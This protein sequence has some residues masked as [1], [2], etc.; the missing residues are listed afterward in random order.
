MERIM[1]L[2]IL[3]LLGTYQCLKAQ[4]KKD[5]VDHEMNS[6]YRIKILGLSETGTWAMVGKY[7]DRNRDTTMVV[8]A[9]VPNT[10]RV[11]II[12]KD[13][14]KSFLKDEAVITFGNNK[15]EYTSLRTL[16]KIIYLHVKHISV[17]PN[18]GQYGIIDESDILSVF[19]VNGKKLYSLNDIKNLP[20]TDQSDKSFVYRKNENG[21]E[22]IDISGNRPKI[23][24]S[25][26]N[27]IKRIEISKSAT[28][29]IIVETERSSMSETLA[30]LNIKNGTVSKPLLPTTKK[31]AYLG[32]IEH[33]SSWIIS[34]NTK[35]LN[36]EI[37][38]IWYGNDGNLINKDQGFNV[39]SNYWYYNTETEDLS[40]LPSQEYNSM[41][42]TRNKRFLLVY[43]NGKIQNYISV[44]QN[45]DM[46]IYDVQT[47]KT[48]KL[49]TIK[50]ATLLMPANGK[51]ILYRS[52]NDKWILTDLD[53]MV[54]IEINEKFL[55]DPAFST[56][57]KCIY[58]ESEKG[59]FTYNILK[60]IL[61]NAGIGNSQ[62]VRIVNKVRT[63]LGGTNLNISTMQ[64]QSVRPILIEVKNKNE[65]T[66]T[67]I[68]LFK[69]KEKILIPETSNKI[70]ELYHSK[71]LEKIWYTSEN[72]NSPAAL[73][74]SNTKKSTRTQILSP[75]KNDLSV[76]DLKMDI[77]S[78]K[79]TEGKPLKGLFYYP[80]DF[81]AAKVYPMVVRIYQVQSTMR[82]EYQVVGY[83]NPVAFDL[84]ALVERGYFVYL[85]DIVFGGKGT[86]LSAL[87]C[88]NNALDALSKRSYIDR[89]KIGLTGHS[90]GGYE[91]NFIATHSDRF[92]AYL[93]GSGNSDILRSYFSYNKNF[94]S[95]FYWQYENGQYEMPSSF[96]EDKELYFKNN[97]IHYV[98]QVNAPILLWAGQK[99]ENIR[100]DQSLEFYIG[101]KRNKKNVIAL[102]YPKQG[103]A[104][105]LGTPERIDLY[106]KVF[107]W[108]DY[109][110]KGKRV[111][112]IDV[113]IKKDAL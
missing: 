84:R 61:T 82:N 73:Y 108:W 4:D 46:D 59:L 109:F 25:T 102:F 24:Y 83:E 54:K 28:H 86:G 43:N 55:R 41:L 7:Y 27:I 9:S 85:P 56:D 34:V 89:S 35:T 100:W 77:I 33:G 37:V 15:A 38:D 107:D 104:L 64:I 65:N 10:S 32:Y 75:N 20:A 68:S 69:N 23:I 94:R 44:V 113:Q 66:V 30:F 11:S 48:V 26:Q 58:F 97:P 18:A 70:R 105:G 12:G 3:Y 19:D 6:Q 111:R 87:D 103:H 2:L 67:Y 53:T 110:L 106:E 99:D 63:N 13:L 22:I 57:G 78:Y 95:P 76:K 39:T 88:V 71:G 98:D 42:P 17:L 21:Y 49:D 91:T 90:H 31:D 60:K 96:A 72:Y 5:V 74:S 8:N 81:D 50:A 45:I 47:K 40:A 14:I 62:Q 16:E 101:L 80:A 93:S 112:W 51:N 1:I 52:M 92:A 29:V 79:N 36:N